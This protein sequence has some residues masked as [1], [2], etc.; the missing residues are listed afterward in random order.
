MYYTIL[1]YIILYYITL[2][3]IIIIINTFIDINFFEKNNINKSIYLNI[4]TI[5]ILPNMDT[6]DMDNVDTNTADT[7]TDA[8][9]TTFTLEDVEKLNYII[10]DNNVYDL[11][12]FEEDHPGG[13]GVL[14][15]F[16][17]KNAT[18]KFHSIPSHDNEHIK[19]KLLTFLKGTLEKK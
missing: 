13:A 12:E 10:I 8:A 7:N 4:Y 9:V 3:Y 5:H 6:A 18:E 15:Y 17:G 11:T 1:Y 2:Y 19:K 16:K 14:R